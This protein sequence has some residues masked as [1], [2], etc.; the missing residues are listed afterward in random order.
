MNYS[1]VRIY[2]KPFEKIAFPL[3][4]VNTLRGALGYALKLSCCSEEEKLFADCKAC[5]KTVGCAYGTCFE[6]GPEHIKKSANIKS[7]DL[8]NLINIDAGFNGNVTFNS[9]DEFVFRITFLG[10]A[11]AYMPLVFLA[12]GKAADGGFTQKRIKCQIAR[13]V[14][15]SDNS[16]IFDMNHATFELPKIREMIIK[17]PVIKPLRS[18]EKSITLNFISPTAFK[19]KNSSRT[20]NDVSDFGRIIGS[21]M[22][23][24]TVFEATEGK[25]LNWNF[26]RISDFAK[27]VRYIGSFA[28]IVKWERISTKQDRIMPASGVVGFATYC[29]KLECF[30]ELLEAAEILRC[31]KNT[32]FGQGRVIVEDYH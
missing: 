29:G 32:N 5:K 18:K 15:E 6:T 3:N 7:K 17:E 16:V 21:L 30:K 20:L 1:T 10:I 19:D 9:T 26:T 4:P 14:D 8:P 12:I 11:V 23:R 31:G 13:I 25:K 28:K 2:F 22:R 27:N 24:Y